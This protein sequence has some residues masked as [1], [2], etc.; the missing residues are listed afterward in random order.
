MA[1]TRRSV[2]STPHSDSADTPRKTGWQVRSSVADAVRVAVEE[3]AARSQNE[4]V[5]RALVEALRD[6]RRRRVFSAYAAAA[7]DDAFM[8]DMQAV[9]ASYDPTSGDGLGSRE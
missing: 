7:L 2:V 9:S 3:G 4:F 6:L 1:I 5:E 8:D